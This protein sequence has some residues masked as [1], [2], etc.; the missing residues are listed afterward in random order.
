M[1]FDWKRCLIYNRSFN[2]RLNHFFFLQLCFELY[3]IF[4]EF[5]VVLLVLH[6]AFY[7]SSVI[8]N[9]SKLMRMVYTWYERECMWHTSKPSRYIFLHSFVR[10]FAFL[11]LLLLDLFNTLRLNSLGACAVCS[12]KQKDRA[13]ATYTLEC[14]R[15]TVCGDI[16][17]FDL[18][19][20]LLLLLCCSWFVH[21]AFSFF[22]LFSSEHFSFY[23]SFFTCHLWHCCCH[24]L[25]GW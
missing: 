9:N 3:L 15:H 8:R 18:L 21:V 17:W 24:W 25:V 14:K 19:L 11:L 6:I 16:D 10:S 23:F 13:R 2:C 22:F 4:F 1:R 20:L 5:S 12:K 7:S